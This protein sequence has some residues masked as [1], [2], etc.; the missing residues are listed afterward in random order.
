MP[1]TFAMHQNSA[2][3]SL[4]KQGDT[5]GLARRTGELIIPLL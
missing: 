1:E 3:Q 5:D 2:W 4:S